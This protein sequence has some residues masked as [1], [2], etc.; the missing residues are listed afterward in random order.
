MYS[1]I[2]QERV[3]CVRMALTI[4]THVCIWRE[5]ISTYI[6]RYAY[7]YVSQRIY[8]RGRAKRVSHGNSVCMNCSH[9]F[10]YLYMA[11]YINMAREGH[12]LTETVVSGNYSQ[13]IA[14]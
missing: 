8:M 2:R 14:V 4:S 1:Y 3:L 11:K 5:N 6:H 9:S 7:I 10:C 12:M 13:T